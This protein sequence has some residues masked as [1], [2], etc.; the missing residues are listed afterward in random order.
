MGLREIFP[1]FELERVGTDPT[2]LFQQWC[3]WCVDIAILRLT[4]KDMCSAHVASSIV[5]AVL[6]S[7]RIVLLCS[8]A[9]FPFSHVVG[10]YPHTATGR[11]TARGHW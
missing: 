1:T 2:V 8:V 9:R 10:L 11:L 4:I 7:P 6:S 5:C 3:V